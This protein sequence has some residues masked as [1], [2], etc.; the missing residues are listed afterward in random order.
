MRQNSSLNGTALLCLSCSVRAHTDSD[1]P[2][3]G[4]YIHNIYI[5]IDSTS[6]EEGAP[7]VQQDGSDVK[8]DTGQ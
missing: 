7:L 5:Y 8:D 4:N 3:I 2:V 6:S 1:A